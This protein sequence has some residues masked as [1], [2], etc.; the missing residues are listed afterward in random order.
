MLI[1]QSQFGHVHWTVF[2][3]RLDQVAGDPRG[4]VGQCLLQGLTGDA[5]LGPR[6]AGPLA[7]KNPLHQTGA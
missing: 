2:C 6:D 4:S 5:S 1:P 3:D 7:G